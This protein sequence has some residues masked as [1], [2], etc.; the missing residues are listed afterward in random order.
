MLWLPFLL[1]PVRAAAASLNTTRSSN[2]AINPKCSSQNS[3]TYESD[4]SVSC[5]VGTQTPVETCFFKD[6]KLGSDDHITAC[7]IDGDKY[8]VHY[9]SV[10]RGTEGET[11]IPLSISDTVYV[12][13]GQMPVTVMFNI[14]GVA[15]LDNILY[16]DVTPLV[17]AGRKSLALPTRLNVQPVK[18]YSD[19]GSLQFDMQPVEGGSKAIVL[20][21]M[22]TRVNEDRT[23]DLRA[24]ISG[25]DTL[26]GVESSFEKK[27][28]NTAV[29]GL[30]GTLELAEESSEE[31][32]RHGSLL[33]RLM[34]L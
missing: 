28:D 23:I 20:V 17:K 21:N 18:T 6:G 26:S 30:L 7:C 12:E 2:S 16:L 22:Q 4:G 14:T 25:Y 31:L 32:V 24:D 5:V 3:R 19:A 11:E 15:L 13:N 1:L 10:P 27:I 9:A 34:S 29:R 8:I 33:W